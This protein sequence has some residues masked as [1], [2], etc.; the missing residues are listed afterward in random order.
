MRAIRVVGGHNL[1]DTIHVEG[2]KNS[3]LKLMAATILAP[4][5]YRISRVPQISDVEVMSD[6]LRHLGATVERDGGTI[7]VDT[8]GVDAWETPY[9]LVNKMRASIS[10]LGPLLARFGKAVVAMPG[11]CQIGARK[12]D[13]HILGLEALGVKFDIEHGYIDASAPDGIIGSNVVLDFPSVGATENLMMASVLCEGRT[14]IDNAA[15]EPEIVDLAEMLISMG[16]DIEG[17]GSPVITI[18]GVESLHPTDHET[19]GDR[20]VAGTYAVAGALTGGP[21][22]VTGFDP[23]HLD[24]VLKR[25]EQMGVTVTRHED[26]VT[27]E[28]TGPLTAI[29]IQT[30]PYPGFPTDM[31]A[32]FMV[33]AA[34]AEGN[35]IIT[36]NVFENRFMFAG[37]IVR[38]GGDVRIEGHHALVTGA[39]RLSGAR[40]ESTDLRGGAS[41]VLAGLVA[42]GETLVTGVEHIERGYE[43]YAEGLASIGAQIEVVEI[44]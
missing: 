28:R 30:L 33:M 21:L 39:G 38:M 15:R 40:V 17:A 18:T 31:Q 27:V 35:S 26:G 44:D 22:T 3:A 24:I 23:M 36:E 25:M 11:G 19:V 7:T 20:V 2:A 12:L 34:M 5:T 8:T 42:D 1:T 6:V 41:L 32:Q 13:I 14:V 10:V 4:G 37:E 16:A 29:D 43:G 9:E